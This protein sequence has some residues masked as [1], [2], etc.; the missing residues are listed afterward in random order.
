MEDKFKS[1]TISISMPKYLLDY[2]D[3]AVKEDL[4]EEKTRSNFLRAAVE[5]YLMSMHDENHEIIELNQE[6]DEYLRQL[7]AKAGSAGK[8]DNTLVR[9]HIKEVLEKA[10]GPLSLSDLVPDGVSRKRVRAVLD[11]YQGSLWIIYKPKEVGKSYQVALIGTK[12]AEE[13]EKM[14]RIQEKELRR[15]RRKKKIRKRKKINKE[16]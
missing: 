1:I 4:V 16:K 5:L 7:R 6:Y 10:E 11:K 14:I 3:Q 9:D 8:T 15:K 13:V 2:I 12:A